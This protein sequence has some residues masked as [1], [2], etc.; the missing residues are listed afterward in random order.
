MSRAAV[1]QDEQHSAEEEVVRCLL[2]PQQNATLLLP[3]TVIAEVTDYTPPETTEHSPD[4]FLGILSW[5]GRNV[6]LVSFD[7]FFEESSQGTPRQLAVLNSL[8]GNREIPFIAITISDLPRLVQVDQD[9]IEYIESGEHDDEQNDE[10]DAILAR[11]NFSGE[12]AVIP[13]IDFIEDRIIQLG[14]Q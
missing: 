1:K 7:N 12:F 6:P 4:W 9:S 10:Q 13:N 11:V 8:N 5:R 14:I 2:L 3:N